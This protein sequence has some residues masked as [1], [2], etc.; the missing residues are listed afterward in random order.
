MKYYYTQ[1]A[2]LLS[3]QARLET[4]KEKKAKLEAKI[5]SCTSELKEV[6]T[7][8]GF[9]NDK[10]SNYI[11]QKTQLENLE[12]EDENLDLVFGGSQSLK[13]KI[14]AELLSF[15]SIS[16]IVSGVTN[17]TK[18][19]NIYNLRFARTNENSTSNK[20]SYLKLAT[21]GVTIFALGLAS[22]IF[23]NKQTNSNS[24]AQLVDDNKFKV[25]Y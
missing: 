25:M 20:K 19:D 24:S 1:Q 14:T 22:G 13:Q 10:Y 11:I 8:N 17:A 2:E 15:A 18:P 3:A 9:S 21:G 23:I 4:L 5:T 16:G 6:M 12:L 7:S